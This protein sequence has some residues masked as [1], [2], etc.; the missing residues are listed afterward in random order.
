MS[1]C[2]SRLGRTGRDIDVTDARKSIRNGE[3]VI[4]K[5]W[6]SSKPQS[7]SATYPGRR[8]RGGDIMSS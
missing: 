8:G 2:G 4:S 7:L 3:A 1:V 5:N 6:P